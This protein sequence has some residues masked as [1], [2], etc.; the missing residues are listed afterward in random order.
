M[1]H[2]EIDE[3]IKNYDIPTEERQELIRRLRESIQQNESEPQNR[4]GRGV[5]HN[6]R[7]SERTTVKHIGS[8]LR[9]RRQHQ[10][11][12]IR[13]EAKKLLRSVP[14]HKNF[15]LLVVKASTFMGRVRKSSRRLNEQQRQ[16]RG[17]VL[18]VSHSL[19]LEEIRT[20][21]L[22]Q[23]V[24]KHLSLCVRCPHTARRY[25]NDVL[26]GS[27]ELWVVHLEGN[28][29]GLLQVHI[30]RI[31]TPRHRRTPSDSQRTIEQCNSHDN[32]PL[33]LGRH[34]A[35]DVLKCLEIDHVEAETFFEVGAFPIFLRE[36]INQP[37]S[38]PIFDGTESHYIWRT[39]DCITIAT[40]ETRLDRKDKFFPSKVKWSNFRLKSPHAWEELEYLNHLHVGKILN[41]VLTVPSFYR[42]VS[43]IRDSR[44]IPSHKRPLESS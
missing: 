31:R 26:D 43:A 6:V 35:L 41:H 40:S 34:I 1:K 22:L 32:N 15:A 30:E 2:H 24:G 25:L 42:E 10:D 39:E 8:A 17:R 33:E 29:V 13:H 16:K 12:Q 21:T 19:R 5:R 9:L 23:K 27:G 18:D 20:V 37:M 14:H 7:K 44:S 28:I 36:E 11:V 4:D 3:L 38:E